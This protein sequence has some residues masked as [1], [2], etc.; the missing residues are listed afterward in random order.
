MRHENE[1][2]PS[3][4][5]GDL[6]NLGLHFSRVQRG[7]GQAETDRH[8]LNSYYARFIIYVVVFPALELTQEVCV[9]EET[10]SDTMDKENRK[11]RL[12]LMRPM[13]VRDSSRGR[14][15]SCKQGQWSW[16]KYRCK[17]LQR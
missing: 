9:R 17:T 6:Q 8:Y 3:M 12:G 14:G 7:M 10:N 13:P 4:T 5:E 16:R 2:G 11:P 15:M 1:F